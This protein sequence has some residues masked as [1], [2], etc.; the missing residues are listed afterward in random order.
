MDRR[1]F[2]VTLATATTGLAAGCVA[3][4]APGGSDGTTTSQPTPTIEST[5]LDAT[6]DCSSVGTA[7]ATFESTAVVVTGC[8]QGPDGCH[9]PV[10]QDAT[11]DGATLEVVVTTESQGGDVCTQALVQRGYEATVTFAGGLPST[12]TVVH[13][14]MGSRETVTTAK[15]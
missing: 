6:G 10:L 9:Q 3:D 8:I 5:A 13:D 11:L 4:D 2:L 12:V 14:S 7:S 1:T 15:R